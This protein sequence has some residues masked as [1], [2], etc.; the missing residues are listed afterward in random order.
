[1]LVIKVDEDVT[2][3]NQDLIDDVNAIQDACKGDADWKGQIVGEGR[4]T[5]MYRM[6]WETGSP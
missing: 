3:T 1:M 6:T 2:I 4:T 5:A